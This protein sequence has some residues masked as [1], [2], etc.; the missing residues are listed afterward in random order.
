MSNRVNRTQSFIRAIKYSF[1]TL[2]GYRYVNDYNNTVKKS[3]NM[4]MTI[5]I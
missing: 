1:K 3:G 4:M 2:K 5:I